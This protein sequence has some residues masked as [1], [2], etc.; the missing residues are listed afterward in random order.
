[1]LGLMA[2]PDE[3]QDLGDRVFQPWGRSSKW[4]GVPMLLDLNT[5]LKGGSWTNNRGIEIEPRTFWEYRPLSVEAGRSTGHTKTLAPGISLP[6]TEQAL[7]ADDVELMRP[8]APRLAEALAVQLDT[9]RARVKTL[10]PIFDTEPLLLLP[11]QPKR[12]LTLRDFH[13][14]ESGKWTDGRITSKEFGDQLLLAYC[15]RR[16]QEGDGK[17]LGTLVTCYEGRLK[18]V[19]SDLTHSRRAIALGLDEPDLK[20]EDKTLFNVGRIVVGKLITGDNGGDVIRAMRHV[21]E[22]VPQRA[23]NRLQKEMLSHAVN[24]SLGRE[25]KRGRPRRSPGYFQ[26]LTA[27]PE[28]WLL[29][30]NAGAGIA[31]AWTRCVLLRTASVLWAQNTWQSLDAAEKN[32]IPGVLANPFAVWLLHADTPA[33][34]LADAEFNRQRYDPAVAG[35]LTD[36][37]FGTAPGRP[38]RVKARLRDYIR[39]RAGAAGLGTRR[40]AAEHLEIRVDDFEQLVNNASSPPLETIESLQGFDEAAKELLEALPGDELDLTLLK[41]KIAKPELTNAQLSDELGI[42]EREVVERFDRMWRRTEKDR[43]S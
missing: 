8:V 40:L 41:V 39:I 20:V 5:E 3:E 37:L 6:L 19:V 24:L 14:R 26:K 4:P 16:A 22:N 42:R 13:N 36:F 43:R 2:T 23:R 10:C 28:L 15:V 12:P 34:V 17:A 11:E 7:T 9:E 27:D 31:E 30:L 33:C 35:N 38:S 18:H 29:T 21:I 32:G 25:E 1:M